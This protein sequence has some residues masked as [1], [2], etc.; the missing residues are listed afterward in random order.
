MSSTDQPTTFTLNRPRPT[1]RRGGFGQALMLAAVLLTVIGSGLWASGIH[2]KF[3]WSAQEFVLRTVPVDRGEV[4]VF[5]LE[6]GTL[7]SSDNATIKCQVE[8]LMG[9]V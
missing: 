1:G 4:R 7:E 3:P 9:M 6:S 8:A 5:V 2:P